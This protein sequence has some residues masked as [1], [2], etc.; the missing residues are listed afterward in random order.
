MPVKTVTAKKLDFNS[1]KKGNKL[2]MTYYLNVNKV[3][4]DG[5]ID[6]TD[7]NG[8]PFT[9][10]G[11]NLIENTMNSANQF[12]DIQKITRTEMVEKLEN[13]RDSV[14]TVN[15]DKQTGENRTLTGYL[16]STEPKMGRSQVIDLEIVTGHAERLVDHRTLNWLISKGIK[17]EL[18]K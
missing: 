17:Y 9:V 11:K 15:F 7:Q 4:S 6:V 18:K 10:R 14:F 2:S 12:T 13:V 8:N 3:N 5:S 16:I 1:L